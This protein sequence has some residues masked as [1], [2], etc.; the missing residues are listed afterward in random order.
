MRVRFTK[1]HC[2]WF[3]GSDPILDPTEAAR[4]IFLGVAEP[5]DKPAPPAP[6]PAPIPEPPVED[7]TDVEPEAPTLPVEEPK[8]APQ[9]GR[10]R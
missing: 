8:P 1:R 4:L 9:R 5:Y 6:K 2:G 3:P 7:P 10:R